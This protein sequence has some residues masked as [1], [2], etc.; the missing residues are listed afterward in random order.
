VNKIAIA[1][2]RNEDIRDLKEIEI[3]CELSPW[4]IDA[5]ES[6][7]KRPD[8]IMLKA[9]REGGEICGFIVG[10]SPQ[11]AGEA[12]IYN[13]GVAVLFRRQGIAAML[14]DEFR[15]TCAER[16]NSSV[17]LEVRVANK[18]AIEF[19]LAHGFIR[20]GVRPGFYADPPDDALLMFAAIP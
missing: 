2:V 8:S 1:K 7:L 6:E 13:L 20:K 10:R 4:T 3:Q 15:R 9:T 14:L 19:Y 5:Y 12:E 18:S 17:W 11:D 16:G